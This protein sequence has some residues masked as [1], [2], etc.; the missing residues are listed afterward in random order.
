MR[1]GP[2]SLLKSVNRS[3]CSIGLG[4]PLGRRRDMKDNEKAD[5]IERRPLLIKHE[6][7]HEDAIDLMPSSFAFGSAAGAY[8]NILSKRRWQILTTSLLASVITA[9]YSFSTKPVYRATAHVEIDTEQR[10][11]ESID[12]PYRSV[13]TDVIFL[14]TQGDVLESDNLAGQTIQQLGL[15]PNAEFPP[16]RKGEEPNLP[17]SHDRA[18]KEFRKRLIVTFKPTSRVIAV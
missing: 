17:A 3:S 10:Q 9:I 4:N 7:S 2:G 14:K 5:A 12:Y 16:D 13:P 8:W 15:T 6:Q 11:T 1:N 18:L